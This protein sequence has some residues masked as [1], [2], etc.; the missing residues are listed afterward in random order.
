MPCLGFADVADRSANI[1]VKLL[2]FLVFLLGPGLVVEQVE[3]LLHRA[4]DG[5]A[6]GELVVLEEGLE[7]GTRDDML[8]KHLD[9]ILLRK[10]GID[11]TAQAPHELVEGPAMLV[12]VGNQCFDA[13]DMLFGNLGDV[14]G[15]K[16]PVAFG[17]DLG[18]QF[19]VEDVLQVVEAHGQLGGELLGGALVARRTV[20]VAVLIVILTRGADPSE[21]DVLRLLA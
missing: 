1:I 10:S 11:V 14:L 4:R 18:H 6:G 21:D 15:P 3:H 8:R 9:S 5:V 13:V 19:G 7:N 12:I 20:A 16:F 17:A 2:E